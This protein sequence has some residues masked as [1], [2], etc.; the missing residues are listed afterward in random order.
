MLNTKKLT[1]KQKLLARSIIDNPKQTL[2][3]AMLSVGYT[4]NTARNP[5]QVVNKQSFVDLMEK[6]GITDN[7]LNEKLKEGFEANR[8]IVTRDEIIDTPDYNSR[9][10]YLETALKLK[11]HLNPQ[12]QVNIQANDYRLVID[13]SQ[14]VKE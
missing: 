10:K 1:I 9:H 2:K 3:T 8:Q 11:N 14:E 12:Y 5:S 7:Y 6:N 4:E 13:D